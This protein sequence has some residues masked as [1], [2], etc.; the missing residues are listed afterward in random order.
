[1]LHFGDSHYEKALYWAEQ[2]K[3][4]VQRENLRSACL[5]R[6]LRLKEAEAAARK[7]LELDP[8]SANAYGQLGSTLMR[9]HR[10]KE[11]VLLLQ[12]AIELDPPNA[13]PHL[14][15]GFV[16]SMQ[17]KLEEATAEYR[18]SIDL[19]PDG[20][21]AHQALS[22]ALREL[23]RPD[24]ALVEAEI[25]L[26]LTPAWCD[27]YRSL[28]G[29]LA[30]LGRYGEAAQRFQEALDFDPESSETYEL[31]GI[32]LENE[33]KLADA[34]EKYR[35]TDVNHEHVG[36]VFEREG[37]Q[38]EAL[39]EYAKAI[40]YRPHYDGFRTALPPLL[41]G[42]KG[43]LAVES[44]LEGLV[45][46]LEGL[47]LEG[48]DDPRIL[49]IL[50]L[51]RL[52]GGKKKDPAKALEHIEKALEKGGS[53][54]PDALSVLAEA[55]LSTGRGLEAARTLEQARALKGARRYL[56]DQLE[57]VRRQLRP[58][59]ASYASIDALLVSL[60]PGDN[61]QRYLAEFRGVAT[62]DDAPQRIAYLEARLL[63]RAG[64]RSEAAK[65]L[66]GLL[67]LEEKRPEPVL[68][69]AEL[70][71]TAGNPE[72]AESE[73]RRALERDIPSREVW[74]FWA[75]V[76]LLEI[77]R[78]P[79]SLLR[80]FP[81]VAP[82]S[83]GDDLQ[84]LFQRLEA[85]DLIRIHSGGEE[86]RDADGALWGRDRFF[87]GGNA[88]RHHLK[89]LREE[90]DLRATERSFAEGRLLPA[91]YRFPLPQGAYRVTLYFL[92][93]RFHTAGRRRFDVLVE[94]KK[95]LKDYEPFAAG[96]GVL[97]RRSFE[98]RVDDGALDIEL[99]HRLSDPVLS[100]LE[101]EVL[102]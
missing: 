12:K 55:K 39:L 78:T 29:A 37:R 52:H 1:M 82:G 11:A 95:L 49:Q 64:N 100:G 41:L 89:D 31:W 7:A 74:D 45:D 87:L 4:S 9:E 65:L 85:R 76:S 43:N 15:C 30:E 101:I 42:L 24:E 56:V 88:V 34:L 72:G 98:T 68:R 13:V 57:E 92:E 18:K 58:D 84:W 81:A 50:A 63:E 33:G 75:S 99:V 70:L 21:A 22:E 91:A 73:L 28:G 93:A 27:T 40:Q 60:G 66:E 67:S 71:R 80:A 94:G 3:E 62:G 20:S 19:D 6:L 23:G 44:A 61:G 17:G 8:K 48:E 77:G 79:A 14:R 16:L 90:G 96:F 51:A 59:L 25:A 53:D 47:L 5:R 102:I 36:R 32:A 26:K 35:R 38:E 2:L 97:D 69:L 83:Y 46:P 86:F 10:L 54:D